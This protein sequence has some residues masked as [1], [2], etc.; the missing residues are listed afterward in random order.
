MY[1]GMT[2]TAARY[3]GW[4]LLLAAC[5]A[6]TALDSSWDTSRGGGTGSSPPAMVDAGRDAAVEKTTLDAQPSPPAAAPNVVVWPGECITLYCISDPEAAAAG[7]C[8]PPVSCSRADAELECNNVPEGTCGEGV[9]PILPPAPAP[10]PAEEPPPPEPSTSCSLV[11]FCNADAI[12]GSGDEER[13]IQ[14]GC[15]V[16][17]ARLECETEV[18]AVCGNVLPPYV[19]YT[20]DG[21]RVELGS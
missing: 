9:V 18:L 5:R 14:T 2:W 21:R 3:F 19:L 4:A 12:D 1:E 20:L 11:A 16:D 6:T 17:A 8:M 7:L 13:C 15:S 10:D